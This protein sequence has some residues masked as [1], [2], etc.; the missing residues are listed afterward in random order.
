MPEDSA[1][2]AAKRRNWLLW[3]G[4]VLSL[5][6]L[7]SYVPVFAKYPVTRDIPWVNYLLFIFSFALLIVGLLRAF[8]RSAL[9]RGKIA[10]PILT[11]L[12]VAALA[13]FLV[14]IFHFSKGLPVSGEAP[15]VGQKAPDFSLEI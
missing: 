12:S 13:F 10:G 14:F 8:R 5:V 9:Y 3:A 7:V 4:F 6:A 11:T 1:V 2:V 15:K